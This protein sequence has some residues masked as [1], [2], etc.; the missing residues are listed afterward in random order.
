MPSPM[1]ELPEIPEWDPKNS[2]KNEMDGI[3]YFTKMRN[4]VA[5]KLDEAP[6]DTLRNL[7][8]G[9]DT[10][11]H[12][13]ESHNRKNYHANP[14]HIFERLETL[15]LEHEKILTAAPHQESQ[16]KKIN[17]PSVRPAPEIPVR[18]PGLFMHEVE[19]PKSMQAAAL[20]K[21]MGDLILK[22]SKN[23]SD[24]EKHRKA[25]LEAA[26]QYVLGKM[27][28]K[29]FNT[30]LD[31]HAGWDKPLISLTAKKAKDLISQACLSQG[32]TFKDGM[33]LETSGPKLGH[34]F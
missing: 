8:K 24:N 3:E 27:T 9:I 20:E 16:V 21:A 31:N 17:S 30:A 1:F 19:K 2:T 26:Q 13:W 32:H 23:P 12:A 34:Q 33:V 5:P 6:N 22:I 29:E 28:P 10:A 25:V 18:S 11:Q 14:S 7:M 15:M 4:I